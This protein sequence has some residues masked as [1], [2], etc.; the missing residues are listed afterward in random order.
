MLYALN[1]NG[2]K[3]PPTKKEQGYCPECGQLLQSKQGQIISHHWAH[4][5]LNECPY[6]GTGETDWHLSWK[7]YV[8]NPIYC[9]VRIGDNRADIRL[10]DNTVIE[11]QHSPI[12]I[13]TIK[14]RELA[15][16]QMIWLFDCQSIDIHLYRKNK[17]LNY[18]EGFHI[19]ECNGKYLFKWKYLK[20]SL[21]ACTKPIYLDLCFDKILK[22]ISLYNNGN[23]YG[24]IIEKKELID[25]IKDNSK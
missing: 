23:G 8:I 10:S 21:L 3:I 20:K 9:E 14:E 5:S 16:N 15:Y 25:Y 17:F 24:E 18:N 19:K 2:I 13:D 6:S 1:I 12:D 4:T 22:I 11:L 7:Q